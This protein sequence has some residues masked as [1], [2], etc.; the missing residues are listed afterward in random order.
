MISLLGK[1]PK[2]ITVAVSGGVD[3]MALLDFL[4]RKHDVTAAFFHHG[5][6][7]SDHAHGFLT[8]YL[9]ARGIELLVGN[10]NTEK[11]VNQSP[12]EHWRNCRYDFLKSIDGMV[13]TGHNLD[14][15]VETWVWSSLHGKSKLIPHYHSNVMRPLLTTKKS[16]LYSWC[17]SKS[18]PW[19]EDSSNKDTKY[20]RNYIRHEMMENVLKVNPGI[21]KMIRK[22]LIDRQYHNNIPNF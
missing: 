13:V 14:D 3:S 15:C 9:S 8:N 10:I 7:T 6:E 22:K 4:S 21:Y 17:I 2:H 1:V 18:V 11:P 20:M 16:E 12:E 19:M 5:T